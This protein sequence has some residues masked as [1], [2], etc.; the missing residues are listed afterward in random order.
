MLEKL[1]VAGKIPSAARAAWIGLSFMAGHSA[2]LLRSGQALKLR[3][4]KR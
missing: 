3:P 2:A 1:V 4:S